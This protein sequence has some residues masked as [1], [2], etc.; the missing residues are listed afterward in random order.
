MSSAAAR[1][2]NRSAAELARLRSAA[3]FWS[4]AAIRMP[5]ITS[6]GT[7]ICHLRP[8]QYSAWEGRNISMRGPTTMTPMASPTHQVSQPSPT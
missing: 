5:K 2:P 1:L 7:A 8:D 3:R 4:T 6:E